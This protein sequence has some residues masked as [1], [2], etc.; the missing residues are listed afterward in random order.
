MNADAPDLRSKFLQL[1]DDC[2]QRATKADNADAMS[3]FTKAAQVARQ[4]ASN[5]YLLPEDA[6]VALQAIQDLRSAAAW[7][8][9]EGLAFSNDNAP[10]AIRTATAI[11][12]EPVE[13]DPVEPLNA[14]QLAGLYGMSENGAR[15]VIKRGFGRGLAGF[16]RHGAL[17]FA[18]ADAFARLHQ[19]CGIG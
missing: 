6:V 11:Q 15:Q 14:R 7:F 16:G 4:Q 10:G 12:R 3:L 17:W 19:K 5:R 8:N 13:R 2:Y 18:D 9:G 1:S